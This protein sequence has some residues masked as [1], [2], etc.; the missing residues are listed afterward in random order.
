MNG[1]VVAVY[2]LLTIVGGIIGFVKAKSRPS[3]I[4]GGTAGVLLLVCAAEMNR[5]SRVAAY[6]SLVIALLLGARFLRTW[7]AHR[8]L[9][10]DLL[11][12]TFSLLTLI[13]VG[14]QLLA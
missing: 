5:G 13:V 14:W 6:G 12:V 9:M 11:M 10:P 1:V 8:R 2:G 4:A 7:R 3:L